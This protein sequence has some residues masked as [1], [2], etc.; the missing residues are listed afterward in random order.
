MSPLYSQIIEEQSQE[1]IATF[2]FF[3]QSYKVGGSFPNRLKTHKKS[4]L[5]P[6]NLALIWEPQSLPLSKNNCKVTIK[7]AR[8]LIIVSAPGYDVTPV[9]LDH[10]SLS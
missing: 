5:P 1:S 6:E 4:S 3:K 7:K 10:I 9:P 8:V 2:D